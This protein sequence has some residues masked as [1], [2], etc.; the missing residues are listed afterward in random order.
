FE[1][2][3][4][5]ACK[6]LSIEEFPR[7]QDP[8]WVENFFQLAMQFAHRFARCIKPPAFFGQADS[9]FAGDDSAPRQHLCEQIVERALYF[10]AH[11]RLAIES[12]GHDVDV[13]VAVAGVT[14]TGDWKS[15]FR[16]KSLGEFEK[17]D[18]VAAR[19]DHILI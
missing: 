2:N 1:S 8:V 10:F 5:L 16:A 11:S 12:V 3:C 19:H 7:I 15:R 13:D 18:N 14:E 4:P 6:K 9:M 17:I